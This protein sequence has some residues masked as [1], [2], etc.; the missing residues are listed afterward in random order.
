METLQI[1]G[2][3]SVLNKAYS[4]LPL[5][6]FI[7]TISGYVFIKSNDVHLSHCAYTIAVCSAFSIMLLVLSFIKNRMLEHLISF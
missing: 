2:D 3:K 6:L 4:S 7:C 5:E 1:A